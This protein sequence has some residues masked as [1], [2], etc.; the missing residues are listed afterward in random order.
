MVFYA[1]HHESVLGESATIDRTP[2]DKFSVKPFLKW[3]GGKRW[4]AQKLALCI[5]KR[6]SNRYYEPFLGGGAIFFGLCPRKA[7]LSDINSDLI[8]TYIQVRDKP[9]EIIDGLK[10]LSVDKESYYHIR[11]EEPKD[12]VER[13]IRF[14]YLNRTAFGGIYRLNLNGKFNVPYGGGSRTPELLWRDGLIKRASHALQGI[15][16]AVSDFE[17]MMNKSRYGDVI[18]CD[19]TYTMI[20]NNNKFIRYNEKNFSWKDQERLSL[21]ALRALKRGTFVLI[22]NASY[23]PLCELYHPFKPIKLARKSLVSRKSRQCS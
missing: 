2:F 13:A 18:Y 23:Y 12:L 1:Q 20:H 11:K 5:S 17:K 10:K 22:S 16:L 3:P 4:I 9:E 14:L 6:L 19:P 8:N 21:V 7:T 15:E